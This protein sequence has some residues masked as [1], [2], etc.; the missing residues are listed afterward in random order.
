MRKK[1]RAAVLDEQLH[2]NFLVC[3]LDH[4]FRLVRG[5]TLH[6]IHSRLCGRILILC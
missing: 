6:E 3:T 4:F 2:N 5:N 1:G